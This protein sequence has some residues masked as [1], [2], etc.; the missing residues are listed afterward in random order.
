MMSGMR[1]IRLLILC[2]A[3][4]TL[5]AQE[6]Q[7]NFHVVALDR[8]DQPVTNLTAD[9]FEIQ[10][11][12][13]PLRIALFRSNDPTTGKDEPPLGP[14][15][16]SNHSGQ[17]LP[18]VTVILYD[19]LHPIDQK[20]GRSQLTKAAA[21]FK[22]TDYVY[23]YI[24][25]GRGPFPVRPLPERQLETTP[26]GPLSPDLI[27]AA[28]DKAMRLNQDFYGS[29]MI[30]LTY[31]SLQGFASR[32][33]GL[34]GRKSIVWISRGI[35]LSIAG[36]QPGY[37]RDYAAQQDR[38]SATLQ[39]GNIA[40]YPVGDSRREMGSQSMGMLNDIANRTGGRSHLDMDVISSIQQA[41][42]DSRA[43]YTLAFSP[44]TAD[45]KYHKVHVA[46]TKNGVHVLAPDGYYPF[47]A[48]GVDDEGSVIDAAQW[49]PFDAGEI[50]LR[51]SIAPSTKNPQA[52]QFGIRIRTSDLQLIHSDA[53]YSG[54]VS[55]TLTAYDAA[56]RPT[57]LKQAGYPFRMTAD[58]Y[59]D[60]QQHG[61]RLSPDQPVPNDVRKIRII[62]FD[63]Y[64]SAIGSLTVPLSG[65]R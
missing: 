40:M 3:C 53:G 33:A 7:V 10:E 65:A 61:I 20:L 15:E 55:V 41:M 57:V 26:N 37:S 6:R 27:D 31:M 63:R 59:R 12:G 58:Q 4:A 36:Q 24:L 25:T 28:F 39:R 11:Q 46:C 32:L 51:A 5:H 16:F 17:P 50:S 29:D 34:P 52:I 62:V 56:G 35:P 44:R 22:S 54:D 23:L 8:H 1:S 45:A 14:R 42:Q 60:A 18:S 38:L 21:N 30:D 49:S 64:S 47:S 2:L 13:K 43:S 9:D 48:A 19:L